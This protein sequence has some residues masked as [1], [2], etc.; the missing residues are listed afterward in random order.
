MPASFL[1]SAAAVEDAGTVSLAGD[2]TLNTV[3]LSYCDPDCVGVLLALQI[4]VNGRLATVPATRTLTCRAT[5][6]PSNL[7]AEQLAQ[8][9]FS[10]RTLAATTLT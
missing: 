7:L 1:G 3:G 9:S 6:S 8:E 2:D 4:F 10:Q 5:I